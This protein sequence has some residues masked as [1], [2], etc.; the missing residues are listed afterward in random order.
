MWPEDRGG[1]DAYDLR[2]TLTLNPDA[3]VA[4]VLSRRFGKDALGKFFLDSDRHA[5][6]RNSTCK[7]IGDDWSC[8]VIGQVGHEFEVAVFMDLLFNCAED[9]LLKLIFIL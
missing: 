6:R 3:E 4:I 9:V 1:H 7:Q 8:N 5:A 2:R